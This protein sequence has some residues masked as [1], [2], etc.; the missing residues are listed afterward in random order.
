[1]SLFS[2]PSRVKPEEPATLVAA[3]RGC[4]CGF[5]AYS[6]PGKNGG[7]SSFFYG[8]RFEEKE[9]MEITRVTGRSAGGSAFTANYKAGTASVHPRSP[10]TGSGHFERRPHARDLW[11]S[12][13][14]VPLLGAKPID[15]REGGYRAVLINELPEFR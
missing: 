10:L 8:A 2:P 1:M 5:V 11:R 3:K 7:G 6:F 4:R 13:I 12:N 15:M 14:R 9:K